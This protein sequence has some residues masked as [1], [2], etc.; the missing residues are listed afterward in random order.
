MLSASVSLLSNGS[1]TSA[2]KQWPG[3]DGV[4]DVVGTFGGATITLQYRGPDA[5]TWLDLKTMDPST[6]AQTT[7][8][9]TANGSIGFS[10]PPNEIRL[11]VTGGTPSA[12]HAAANRIPV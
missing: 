3:G 10:L 12:L 9:L 4:V 11:V 7:V 6:G 1:A 2:A 5:S 8:S